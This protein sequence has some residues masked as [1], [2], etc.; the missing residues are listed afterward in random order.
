MWMNVD[1]MIDVCGECVVLFGCDVL[2]MLCVN[3][4]VVVLDVECGDD[5]VGCCDGC[6]CGG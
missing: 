3:V 4:D 1:M 5:G 6:V 2:L